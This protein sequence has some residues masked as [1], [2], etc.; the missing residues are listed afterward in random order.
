MR[1]SLGVFLVTAGLTWTG[2][3]RDKAG[4]MIGFAGVT[5]L[6]YGVLKPQHPFGLGTH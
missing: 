6:T 4:L 3:L 1:D 5:L 2:L